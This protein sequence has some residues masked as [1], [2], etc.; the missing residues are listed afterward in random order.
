MIFCRIGIAVFA[1]DPIRPRAGVAAWRTCQLALSSHSKL[2]A[3]IERGDR[4]LRVRP[5]RA[6]D[7][8]SGFGRGVVA[9][10]EA[11]D[12]ADD[13]DVLQGLDQR[14]D[15]HHRRWADS[16]QSLSG[17]CLRIDAVVKDLVRMTES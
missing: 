7:F 6:E 2:T 5:E 9:I 1:S 11:I 16:H 12:I 3:S 15:G 13:P 8:G 14:R 4:D 17:T 10:R